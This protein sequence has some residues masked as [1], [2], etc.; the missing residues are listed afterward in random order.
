MIN[1]Q[2]VVFGGWDAPICYNDLHILDMCKCLKCHHAEVSKLRN[3]LADIRTDYLSFS[4]SPADFLSVPIKLL[5]FNS[6]DV[7]I[8][9]YLKNKKNHTPVCLRMCVC[10]S[11]VLSF[12]PLHSC[13]ARGLSLLYRSMLQ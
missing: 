7:K 12:E 4:V 5:D 8:F 6:F 13:F 9:F 1:D 10:V 2:L 11:F 3:G